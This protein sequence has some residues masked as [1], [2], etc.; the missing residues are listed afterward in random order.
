MATGFVPMADGDGF[1]PLNVKDALSYLDRV[2]VTF[3]N[4]ANGEPSYT[5]LVHPRCADPVLSRPVYDK[6]LT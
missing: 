5:I 2:K 1:R 6:F 4:D 3:S